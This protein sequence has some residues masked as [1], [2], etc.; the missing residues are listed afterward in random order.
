M[1]NDHNI[2]WLPPEYRPR[3]EIVQDNTL[4]MAYDSSRV[5]IARFSSK[6]FPDLRP[7]QAQ[8]PADSTAY[9]PPLH[10]DAPTETRPDTRLQTNIR[11][12]RDGEAQRVYVLENLRRKSV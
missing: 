9:E 7:A 5:T 12:S 1:W 3:C 6:Y 8:G 2:L 4:A 11:T 10:S